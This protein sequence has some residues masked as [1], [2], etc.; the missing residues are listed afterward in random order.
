MD[1]IGVIGSKL[2][3]SNSFAD[4]LNE[5]RNDLIK[6]YTEKNEKV[7]INRSLFPFIELVENVDE[8]MHDQNIDKVFVSKQK[9]HL[10]SPA[11]KAG[12]SVRVI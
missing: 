10:I 11:L 12:K 4:E 2:F 9:I 6:I 1:T 8:I 5:N 3:E 7:F